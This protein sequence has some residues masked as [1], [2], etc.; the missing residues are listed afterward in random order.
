MSNKEERFI[1]FV[2]K[3]GSITSL[4]AFEYLGET[5]LSATVYELR[6]KGV[7]ISDRWIECKN[8]FGESVRYKE[9]FIE[10]DVDIDLINSKP[11]RKLSK[12]F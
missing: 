11:S 3:H 12:L 4:E 7:N 2:Q 5:R 10:G 1:K 8:R 6:Q 9:Y